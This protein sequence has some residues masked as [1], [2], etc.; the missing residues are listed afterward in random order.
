MNCFKA[1]WNIIKCHFNEI[2]FKIY[3]FC[4]MW[5]SFNDYFMLEIVAHW[6]Q[7]DKNLW[8]VTIELF[9]VRSTHIEANITNALINVLKKYEIISKFE[10]IMLNN[11]INND[12][13]IQS[14]NEKLV[15]RS[16][17]IR[18]SWKRRWLYCSEYIF[19]LIIK[20][21]LFEK[22]TEALK[23]KIAEFKN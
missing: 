10:Y 23:M 18:I 6:I 14:I 19:N 5:T 16:H 9:K 4:N 22:D 17:D 21:L 12:I 20:K 13:I 2:I 3:I 15:Q 1:S 8:S 11:V 7:I